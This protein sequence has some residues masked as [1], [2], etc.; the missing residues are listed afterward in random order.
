VPTNAAGGVLWRIGPRKVQ[1]ALVHRPRYDDWTLPKGKLKPG[2]APLTAA[3]REVAE[4]TGHR[5][6]AQRR[7]STLHY[8]SNGA[9][10]EV[11]YWSMRARAGRFVP[12]P[13]VDELR[14][15]G[16]RKAAA[17]LS[18]AADQELVEEFFLVPPATSVVLLGRHASAGK[19]SDWERPDDARPL[20]AAGRRDAAAAAPVVAAFAPEAVYT[21]EL[22]RCRQTAEPVATV[23]DLRLQVAAELSDENYVR[24]PRRALEALRALTAMYQVSYVC[25]QGLTIPGLLGDLG[26]SPVDT[27]KGSLWVV[28]FRDDELTFA[29]YYR[30]PALRP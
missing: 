5:A 29:D 24:R 10:K 26:I 13:E 25:S 16:P 12:G 3:V 11:S 23:T 27:H 30:R 2:E 4:E 15:C 8:R 7:L 9:V 28:G 20:D 17:L 18:Y 1:I 14:W 21:A 22:L 19:R 6:A